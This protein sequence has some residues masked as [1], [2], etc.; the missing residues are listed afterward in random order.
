MNQ[1]IPKGRLLIIGGAEDKGEEKLPIANHNSR[2]VEME[3]LKRIS[4]GPSANPRIEVVTTASNE[5][6]EEKKMYKAAFEKVGYTNVGFI[7]IQS[8]NDARD[9]KY[10]KQVKKAKTVLF[11]GGDQLKIATIIG[12]TPF[13][14][15]V[16]E[17]YY[18]DKHFT[19][20][21]TSAGAAVI[22][23][24]MIQEGGTFEALFGKD[25]KIGGGIGL[26]EGCIVDTHFIKRGRFGRLAH[27]IIRNP[28]QIGIG[29]G[30]D[31]AL[32]IHKGHEAECLGSG[33]VVIIDGNEIEQTNIN[34][35]EE[36]DA[37]YV[38]NLRVH[39]LIRDCRFDL[40]SYQRKFPRSKK[41]T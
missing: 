29:L 39:L 8:K 10:C 12:G 9:E 40:Q 4:S 3:I 21:G 30:E 31:T 14:E 13:A 19:V 17:Q 18:T 26:L 5:P 36:N 22:S 25:L 23:K 24:V 15:V 37:I 33:M 41:K 1:I 20:A 7:D 35:V 16:R 27:A 6:D 2:F 28:G 38:D 32:I 34:E 11:A